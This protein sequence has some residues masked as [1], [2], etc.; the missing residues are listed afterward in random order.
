LS[1]YDTLATPMTIQEYHWNVFKNSLLWVG[2]SATSMIA[3]FSLNI[4]TKLKLSDTKVLVL[5]LIVQ[6]IGIAIVVNWNS[7][8]EAPP[9]WRFLLGTGLVSLGFPLSQVEVIAIYSKLLGEKKGT[10][11][12]LL[13]AGGA[14]ARL[15][16]PLWSSIVYDKINYGLVFLIILSLLVLNLIILS[17]FGIFGTIENQMKAR[18]YQAIVNE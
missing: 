2:I 10:M 13:T 5:S 4:M 9:L 14:S 15:A 8:K 3:F 12:G 11:L 17:I 1:V 18:H 7:W 16:G 6:I